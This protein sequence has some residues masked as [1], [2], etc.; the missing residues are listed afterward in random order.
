MFQF[1]PNK[2]LYIISGPKLTLTEEFAVI[3]L[4]KYLEKILLKKIKAGNKVPSQ[5]YFIA[6][7][8][9]PVNF[10]EEYMPE[11]ETLGQEGFVICSKGNGL[12][13]TGNTPRSILFGVYRFLEKYC[14]IHW[15]WPGKDAEFLPGNIRSIS[16]RE[17]LER[18][19]PDFSIRG[20]I[21]ANIGDHNMEDIT[22]IIDWMA[23]N[24]INTFVMNPTFLDVYEK[25]RKTIKHELD[26]R[27]LDI[28]FGGGHSFG[29]LLPPRRYFKDHPEYYALKGDERISYGQPC[30]SNPEVIDIISGYI[31]EVLE[32]YPEFKM[33]GLFANDIKL[34]EYGFCECDD[35]LKLEEQVPGILWPDANNN[36]KSYLRFCAKIID[37]TRKLKKTAHFC[38]FSYLN[39]IEPPEALPEIP[40]DTVMMFAPYLRCLNH[41]LDES[42]CTGLNPSYYKYLQDWLEKWPGPV[43]EF[44][45]LLLP[46]FRSLTYSVRDTIKKTAISN[47]RLGLSGAFNALSFIPNNPYY[48]QTFLLYKSMWNADSDLTK[49][50]HDYLSMQYANSAPDVINYFSTFEKAISD[51]LEVTG[52]C[53]SHHDEGYLLYLPDAMLHTCQ[54]LLD[55]A[56]K[57]ADSNAVKERLETL[58]IRHRYLEFRQKIGRILLRIN[59]YYIIGDLRDVIRNYEKAKS[60]AL[61]MI[62]F[63]KA[64]SREGGFI[65]EGPEGIVSVFKRLIAEWQREITAMQEQI[66]L[67]K[68]QIKGSDPVQGL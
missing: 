65:V 67:R 23:K 41:S 16:F 57:K 4:K 28:F 63:V 1:I 44:G 35:C 27:S 17:S 8:I 39:T 50:E 40:E 38:V 36:T 3:E 49:L 11:K 52:L 7:G 64:N 31:S 59:E 18:E 53:H 14:D 22:V 20:N 24:Q 62:E 2:D 55:N 42:D 21:I 10:P 58:N 56:M 54:D 33:V 43:I 37:Q 26:K 15:L 29:S 25:N 48:L 46:N 30:F 34:W 45:Y 51:F 68:K 47:R 12:W 60:L 32:R 6:A 5:E 61:Q 13:I 9:N 19:V 66:S